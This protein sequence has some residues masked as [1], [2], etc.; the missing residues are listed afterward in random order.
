[1]PE[2]DEELVDLCN[3]QIVNELHASHLYLS[4]AAY[5][6]ELGLHGCSTFMRAQSVEEREHAMRFYDHLVDRD[7]RV[8]IGTVPE[9]PNQWDQPRA[10]FEDALG[11]EQKVTDQIERIYDA[12]EDHG[13]RGLQNMLDWFVDEQLEEEHTFQRILELFD[14]IGTDG[15]GLL[16]I[17]ERLAD[18]TAEGDEPEGE[19]EA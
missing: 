12:A 16:E 10:A 4:M 11:H 6:D 5:F 15:A 8:G 18:R 9:T 2:L 19:E 17:D 7:A 1:M 14:H 3:E 13:D